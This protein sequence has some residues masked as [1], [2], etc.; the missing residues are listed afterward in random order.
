MADLNTFEFARSI[1]DQCDRAKFV[2]SY[3]TQIQD[4]TIVKIRAFLTFDAF[5][6]V[7]YNADTGKCSYAL[8]NQGIRVFGADNAFVGWHVHPFDAP[9]QHIP[10]SEISFSE[11]LERIEKQ[12]ADQ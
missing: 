3:D 2:V 5:I 9:A 1:Q 8:I 4:N 7:F 12:Y 6:D 11:F 10:S